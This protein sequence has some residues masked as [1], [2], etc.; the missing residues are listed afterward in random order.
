MAK[1]KIVLESEDVEQERL[2]ETARDS[3]DFLIEGLQ[4]VGLEVKVFI[5]DDPE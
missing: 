1:V 5:V 3:M 4:A 2:V